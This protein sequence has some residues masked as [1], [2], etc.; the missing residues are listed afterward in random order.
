MPLYFCRP[1]LLLDREFG[2]VRMAASKLHQIFPEADVGH[3]VEQQPLLLIEDVDE[4]IEDLRRY[5]F[6]A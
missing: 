4:C 5:S 1:S 3:L 2:H 6:S